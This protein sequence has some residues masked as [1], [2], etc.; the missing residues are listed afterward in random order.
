MLSMDHPVRIGPAGMLR[1][2]VVRDA[3]RVTL[4]LAGE[5]DLASRDRF[6]GL[7]LEIEATGPRAI[8]VDLSGL[9]FMDSTGVWSLLEAHERAEG[10]RSF[11]V[12]D[13]SGPAHRALSLVGADEILRM[14]D[15]VDAD[16]APPL[17]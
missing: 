7:M 13:G 6:R 8:V 3:D 4:G 12:L 5:F 11:L 16:G 17:H 9:T 15:P 1:G 2:R 10:V 14:A